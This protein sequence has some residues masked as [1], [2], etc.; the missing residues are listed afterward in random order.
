[1][2]K[3]LSSSLREAF[4]NTKDYFRP[5]VETQ[6]IKDPNWLA[7]FTSGEGCFYIKQRESSKN[8]IV[9]IIFS[10]GQH[11]RYESLMGTLVNYL[12][13]EIGRAHV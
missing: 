10:I 3:G 4:P 11:S 12:G 9:E 1:M 8:K 6:K 5:L 7:G 13:S 2:Y